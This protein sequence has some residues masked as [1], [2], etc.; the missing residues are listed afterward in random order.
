MADLSRKRERERLAKRREPHWQKLATGRYLGFRRGPDTWVARLR[1]RA[2]KQHYE[3]LNADDYDD[4]K[5]KAERWFEQL[6]AA[7]VRE[8]VRGTVADA[9][10]AY[11][12]HLRREG[13]EDTAKNADQRFRQIVYSDPL[14]GIRMTNLTRHDLHDWRGRLMEGRQPRSVNR[15]V[16]GVVAALNRAVKEGFAGDPSAWKLDRLPDATEEEGAAV[17]LEPRHRAAMIEA[18]PPAAAKLMRALELTGA[19]PKELSAATVADF[20]AKAGSLTLRHK[21]GR[22][23]RVKVR[24]VVLS[25][26]G[27]AFFR[28]QARDKLPTAPLLT[29]DRGR[30]WERHEWARAFRAASAAVNERATGAARIPTGASMYAFRHSRIAELLQVH[31]ID[32]ITVAQQTGTSVKM[33]ETHYFKFIQG[34]L[35][36]KLAALEERA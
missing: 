4:A 3:A 33:I 32:P 12:D 14:A 28:E 30:A 13:R 27:V 16:A 25:P 7:P 29:D 19:R 23:A 8:A 26:A 31:G 22:P 24:A 36:D 11:V 21:K 18:A 6:G 5:A 35:R 2:G 15:H 10:R 9:C 20:D 17:F 1:D 34:A